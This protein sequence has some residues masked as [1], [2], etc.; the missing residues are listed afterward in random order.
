MYVS[1]S[2]KI[3]SFLDSQHPPRQSLTDEQWSQIKSQTEAEN[4][5]LTQGKRIGMFE[6]FG[7]INPEQ[8]V[9]KRQLVHWL[10]QQVDEQL[11]RRYIES[12]KCGNYNAILALKQLQSRIDIARK[13]N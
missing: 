2:K 4:F 3:E 9:K 12:A 7:Q 11:L 10:D 8:Q 6:M 13:N 5:N 1:E